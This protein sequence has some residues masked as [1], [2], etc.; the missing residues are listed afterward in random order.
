L[1][2]QTS[3][4]HIVDDMPRKPKTPPDD[5]EQSKRFIEA[6]REAGAN[7]SPEAFERVFK[8]ITRAGKAPKPAAPLRRK[9]DDKADGKDP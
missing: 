4:P 1:D 2:G 6:A 5:P 3:L 9:A 8:R 7:E